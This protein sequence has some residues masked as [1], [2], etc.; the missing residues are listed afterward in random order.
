MSI[1]N[2]ASHAG[3]FRGARIS[4]LSREEGIGEGRNTSSPKNACVGGY[5]ELEYKVISSSARSEN[6]EPRVMKQ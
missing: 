6:Y 4:S 2:L 1:K 5:K 3:I